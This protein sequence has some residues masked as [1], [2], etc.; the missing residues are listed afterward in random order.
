MVPS[1]LRYKKWYEHTFHKSALTSVV[2]NSCGSLLAAGGLDGLVSVWDVHTG[3]ILHCINARTPVHSLVWSSGPEGF[4]FGC[5][6]GIL[7][8]VFLEQVRFFLSRITIRVINDPPK[9]S[10][11]STY[12]HAHSEPI[13]CL[14]PQLNATLLISGAAGEVT[15]WE[16]DHSTRDGQTI[17]SIL[18]AEVLIPKMAESW[19]V[20]KIIPQPPDQYSQSGGAVQV[21]ALHWL[22]KRDSKE[23][24]NRFVVA[25]YQWHGVL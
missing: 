11:R 19:E 23:D 6:N 13:H 24:R 17:S 10:I 15:V 16:R 18:V 7:V 1:T 2:F 4:I 20:F 3:S 25:S 5:E 8:S 21:T 12:F 22:Y 9:A 14:S